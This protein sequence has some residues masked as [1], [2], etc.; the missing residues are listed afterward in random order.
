MTEQDPF[1]WQRPLMWMGLKNKSV[2]KA[3]KTNVYNSL[4]KVIKRRNFLLG[5]PWF[6]IKSC[7]TVF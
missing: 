4:E 2:D 3:N 7:Y 5:I 1:C 6:V